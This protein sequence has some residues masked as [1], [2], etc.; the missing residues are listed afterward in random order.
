VLDVAKLAK[1]LAKVL[2]IF[3]RWRTGVEPANSPQ[4]YL[5]RRGERP[6][7]RRANQAADKFTTPHAS[8]RRINQWANEGL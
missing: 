5:R 2:Q 1:P 6:R 8:P 3:V 7:D 4:L